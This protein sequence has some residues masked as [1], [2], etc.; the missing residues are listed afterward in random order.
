MKVSPPLILALPFITHDEQTAIQANPRFTNLIGLLT[1]LYNFDSWPPDTK[2]MITSINRSWKD[3][4]QRTGSHTNNRAIDLAPVKEVIDKGTSKISHHI[5][6]PIPLNRN[7]LLVH[8]LK[9]L[10]MKKNFSKAMI[11]LIA[12]EADHMHADVMR[13]EGG[14]I[15]YNEIRPFIETMTQQDIE[16]LPLLNDK[17]WSVYF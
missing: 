11:P 3:G 12:L 4:S 2:W 5:H 17:H 16:K 6:L 7:M 13:E 9:S 8:A 15:M 10:I 14:L 1:D